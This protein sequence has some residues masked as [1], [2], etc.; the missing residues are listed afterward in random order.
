[1]KWEHGR[2]GTSGHCQL[3]VRLNFPGY[4]LG[5]FPL[6]SNKVWCF[7]V[8]YSYSFYLHTF[9][10]DFHKSPFFSGFQS[11]IWDWPELSHHGLSLTASHGWRLRYYRDRGGLWERGWCQN[12]SQGGIVLQLFILFPPHLLVSQKKHLSGWVWRDI[13]QTQTHRSPHCPLGV[14][15]W[16]EWQA[17][18]A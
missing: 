10:I 18:W 14:R 9:Y 8:W 12:L 1:M 4:V 6:S 11:F 13:A 5:E 15:G 3:D 2:P 7:C 16:V 17:E